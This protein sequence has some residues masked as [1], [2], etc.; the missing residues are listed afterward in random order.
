MA[1]TNRDSD[2]SA[3]LNDGNYSENAFLTSNAAPQDDTNF[4]AANPPPKSDHSR[5]ASDG[6]NVTSALNQP[7]NIVV[8]GASFA[9]L[10]VGHAFLDTAA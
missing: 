10:S 9:G 7:L 1:N 8:L 3:P 4:P 6:T 2:L 5:T